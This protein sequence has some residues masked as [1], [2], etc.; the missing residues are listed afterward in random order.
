[1]YLFTSKQTLKILLKM[2]YNDQLCLEIRGIIDLDHGTPFVLVP[3][4]R[5]PAR[6]FALSFLE[7]IAIPLR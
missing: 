6:S 2:P 4:E 5:R 3:L 7:K 1:M